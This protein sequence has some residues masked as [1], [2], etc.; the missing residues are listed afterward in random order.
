MKNSN[1]LVRK[2]RRK[3][4]LMNIAIVFFL[5]LGGFTL[6][7]KLSFFSRTIVYKDVVTSTYTNLLIDEV[8]ENSSTVLA[9]Y[10][11][12][13]DVIKSSLDEDYFKEEVGSFLAYQ[14]DG[15]KTDLSDVEYK[16]HLTVNITEALGDSVTTEQVSTIVSELLS[17]YHNT[18]NNTVVS[19]TLQS[20]ASLEDITDAIMFWSISMVSIL[21]VFMIVKHKLAG[22]LECGK[23]FL[24]AGIFIALLA[25]IPFENM[26]TT[27]ASFKFLIYSLSSYYQTYI[28]FI[29]VCCA[30]AFVFSYG[31]V[32][33]KHF[34]LKMREKELRM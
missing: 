25:F 34:Y 13:S 4:I 27:S 28:I 29:V 22:F 9:K 26:V 31:F 17:G 6:A 2:N 7:L 12:D 3:S 11:L 5:V 33:L 1:I 24:I 14:I 10:N 21:C 18:L 19:S 8:I 30:F 20:Y 23:D 16:N 32:Y 15:L